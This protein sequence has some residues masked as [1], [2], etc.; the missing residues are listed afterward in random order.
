MAGQIAYETVQNYG[1]SVLP[2]FMLM[3]N[4]VDQSRLSSELYDAS[5]AF[6]GHRRGGLAM[7]TI[8]A[9]G[10]FAAVCG[11][12]MATAATMAKVAMPVDAP[13]RLRATGSP[14]GAIAAGGTLGILIP[15]TVIM[16]I[17]GIMTETDIGKLFIAGILPGI[18]G[19]A[20]LR[21]G[22]HGRGVARSRRRAARPRAPLA[23]SAARRCARCGRL[24]RCSL[25][26][27]GGIYVGVFTPTE[28]A[29][30]GAAGA[31]AVR[32]VAR[33]SLD[34][35]TLVRDAASKRRAPPR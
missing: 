4:F 27:I 20:L 25:L 13:L 30:I 35:P 23:G 7:A 21:G 22:D 1:L 33:G 29:G 28:A 26:V 2:L 31:F 3:G 17:Y 32:A 11:S 19:I 16:V 9:C 10:G 34:L 6:L 12:S 15:P 14:R 24:P 5:N 18:V 8:V